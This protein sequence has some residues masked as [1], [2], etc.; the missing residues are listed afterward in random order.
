MNVCSLKAILTA[1]NV[2]IVLTSKARFVWNA[3]IRLTRWQVFLSHDQVITIGAWPV[4]FMS[5]SSLWL[6]MVDE[7]SECFGA[8]V[9]IAAKEGTVFLVQVTFLSISNNYWSVVVAKPSQIKSFSKCS[10]AHRSRS[11]LYW[12]ILEM[13]ELVFDLLGLKRSWV[14]R[15]LSRSGWKRLRFLTLAQKALNFYLQIRGFYNGTRNQHVSHDVWS[16]DLGLSLILTA[17]KCNKK[18]G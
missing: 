7:F 4:V 18:C 17:Y 6:Q 10:L 1:N 11:A 13:Y 3:L 16:R 2:V 5:A 14:P 8:I 9:V 12:M 15:P